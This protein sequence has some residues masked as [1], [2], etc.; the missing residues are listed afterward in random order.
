MTHSRTRSQ[1]F[2]NEDGVAGL[3]HRRC[4]A[5]Y[6]AAVYSARLI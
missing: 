1:I 5:H 2:F 6:L 4:L 3:T